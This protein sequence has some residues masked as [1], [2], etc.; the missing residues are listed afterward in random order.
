VRTGVARRSAVDIAGIVLR[1]NDDGSA[2]TIGDV[3]SVT[4]TGIDRDRAYFVGEDPAISIRVD[5][6]DRGDAIGI[7]EQV[8]AVAEAM[9]LT[10]P[11]G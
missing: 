8:E 9:Q 1:N 4:E 2:L 3:A 7:Q 11:D 6:S 5:R 10:L